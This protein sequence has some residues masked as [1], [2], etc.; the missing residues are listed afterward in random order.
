MKKKECCPS[1]EGE[2]KEDILLQGLP[3]MGL[4]AIS[5]KFIPYLITRKITAAGGAAGTTNITLSNNAETYLL[6]AWIDKGLNTSYQISSA[7]Y[8]SET[9]YNLGTKD[10]PLNFSHGGYTT[11]IPIKDFLRIDIANGL[12][13][14]QDYEVRLL[15]V[16]TEPIPGNTNTAKSDYLDNFTLDDKIQKIDYVGGSDPIYIGYAEPGT[17]TG[18][19]NWLIFKCNYSASN[20]VSKL[21]AGGSKAFNSEWD[22]RAGY[23]Y[24]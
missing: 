24:S 4:N 5:K 13:A 17:P 1:N 19:E 9:L 3:Q 21:A 22:E 7:A 2:E 6:E 10:S 20:L 14:A 11:G 15:I 16:S 18:S 23:T 12:G 8:R